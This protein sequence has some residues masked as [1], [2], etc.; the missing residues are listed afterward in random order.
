MSFK[1]SM[2]HAGTMKSLQDFITNTI[3]LLYF[4]KE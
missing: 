2:M 3:I 4:G 1:F